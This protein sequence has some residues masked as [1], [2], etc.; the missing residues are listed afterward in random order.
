MSH[1]FDW[2]LLSLH[3]FVTVVAAVELWRV[4]WD[5]PRAGG[6][7][8]YG[9]TLLLAGLLV[10]DAVALPAGLMRPGPVQYNVDAVGRAAFDLR[11][12]GFDLLLLAIP[13]TA[14]GTLSAGVVV[15]VG[16]C[17]GGAGGGESLV[18]WI[19]GA[20]LLFAHLVLWA[21][22]GAIPMA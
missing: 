17:R 16:H 18:A 11:M 7:T 13:L 3:A 15:A 10:S 8:R 9:V 21:K 22:F 6:P 20:G 1:A 2:L 4:R 19:F 5:T 14:L 12:W